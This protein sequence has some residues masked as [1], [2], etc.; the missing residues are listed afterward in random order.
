MVSNLK[1]RRG[2]VPD[3]APVR[4]TSPAREPDAHI[5]PIPPEPPRNGATAEWRDYADALGVSYPADARRNQIIE[6]VDAF[7][8]ANT[9]GPAPET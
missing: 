8:A 4:T 3:P 9:A 7:R 2:W 1:V 6:A 5:L